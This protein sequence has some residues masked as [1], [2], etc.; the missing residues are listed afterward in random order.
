MRSGLLLT[1]TLLFALILPSR[2]ETF[3]DIETAVVKATN[4]FRKKNNLGS[5]KD[6]DV[7]SEVARRHSQEML[8]LKYFSHQSPTS[9]CRT[10]M[11]R[12][13]GGLRFCLVSAENLHKNEGYERSET[14]D[15]A[16]D[17]WI[18]S[19]AHL[20]NLTNP[21]FNRVGVGV[22]HKGNV[23]IFTQLF[24]YEPVIIQSI[25]CSSGNPGYHIQMY[26]EITDGPKEGGVFFN[27]KRQSN[28]QCL[29]DGSFFC[30][31]NLPGPGSLEIGQKPADA[32]DWSI[33]TEI[34][35]P[36]PEH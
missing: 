13:R 21:R 30:E 11:D 15:D 4:E 17:G 24:S 25:N 22:A 16:M 9:T 28:F 12:L 23:Y 3:R 19:P 27:G 20:K 32:S 6:D 10:V 26:A 5:L 34:P 1:S 14:A 8:E 7:L 33:E 29:P 36:L 35:I 18:H 2:S 31:L